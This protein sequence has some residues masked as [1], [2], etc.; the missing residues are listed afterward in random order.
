MKTKY[1]SKHV[2]STWISGLIKGFFEGK[3][4]HTKEYGLKDGSRIVVYAE[5]LPSVPFAAVEF[6]RESDDTIVEF[7]PFGKR[8][9][10]TTASVLASLLAPIGG[11][12]LVQRDLKKKEFMAR[13]ENEFWDFLDNRLSDQADNRI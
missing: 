3:G 11:G 8:E 4:L 6:R 7:L 9:R 2:E 1:E 12:I 5:D 10:G 13:V